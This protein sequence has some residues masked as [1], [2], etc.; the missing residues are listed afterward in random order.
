[1]SEQAET[2]HLCEDKVLCKYVRSGAVAVI[3]GGRRP[4]TRL[5]GMNV[6]M[7]H[8]ANIEFPAHRY[9]LG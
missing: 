2:P 7:N 6:A 8:V 9:L 1:M 3:E 4:T 5:L